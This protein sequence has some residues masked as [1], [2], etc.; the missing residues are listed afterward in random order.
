MYQLLS[1]YSNYRFHHRTLIKNVIKSLKNIYNQFRY[2]PDGYRIDIPKLNK[3]IIDDKFLDY[4]GIT[5][6]EHLKIRYR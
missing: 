2:H 1:N 6:N 5:S 4:Y 3:D